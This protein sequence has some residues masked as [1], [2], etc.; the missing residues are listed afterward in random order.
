[1]LRTSAAPISLLLLALLHRDQS[2]AQVG[3]GQTYV[4]PGH[5]ANPGPRLR[6]IQPLAH[7]TGVAGHLA[8]TLARRKVASQLALPDRLPAIPYARRKLQQ[9]LDR[10]PNATTVEQTPPLEGI[11]AGHYW[12]A[13]RDVPVRLSSAD[14]RYC[15]EEGHS[16][17][18]ALDTRWPNGL[19][20]VQARRIASA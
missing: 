1:V 8:Q 15:D 11:A 14:R 3:R 4:R 6:R 18:S 13:W 16:E 10:L 7:E 20:C 5:I 9:V 17:E 19:G 12:P 2:V